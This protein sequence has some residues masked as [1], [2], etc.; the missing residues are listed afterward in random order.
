[1]VNALRRNLET[2]GLKRIARDA[3]F[4]IDDLAAEFRAKQQ[5][6]DE[7]ELVSEDGQ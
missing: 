2:I 3:T 7:A 4:T 1:M 5:E 6:A